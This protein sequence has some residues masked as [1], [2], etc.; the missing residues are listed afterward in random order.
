M[1]NTGVPRGVHAH[2]ATP[3]HVHELITSLHAQPTGKMVKKPIQRDRA[4]G[5]MKQPVK[6][7][8][9]A[10]LLTDG[11]AARH[12]RHVCMSKHIAPPDG[13]IGELSATLATGSRR[14]HPSTT[15]T[16]VC[17][18]GTVALR[19][20]GNAIRV[21]RTAATVLRQDHPQAD[22]KARPG[23]HTHSRGAAQKPTMIT[24]ARL[25]VG[26]V[27]M[28]PVRSLFT[29]ITARNRH[30]AD[31]TDHLWAAGILRL[32]VKEGRGGLRKTHTGFYGAGGRSS[33]HGGLWKTHTIHNGARVG[34]GRGLAVGLWQTPT[35]QRSRRVGGLGS[36]AVDGGRSTHVKWLQKLPPLLPPL[37]PPT[38][39][40]PTLLPQ[41]GGGDQGGSRWGHA[42]SLPNPHRR[43]NA[44]R[45][46][47]PHD[48]TRS[49]GQGATTS[50]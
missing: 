27:L 50:W 36:C 40:L 16:M 17:M 37:P 18:G 32:G 23:R 21:T 28:R 12:K 1:P 10:M 48:H 35:S 3:H 33:Q 14:P 31:A 38:P 5:S 15:S 7:H 46:A 45:P 42:H 26:C 20:T 11:A 24:T 29:D 47:L 2:A 39:S 30:L 41:Q 9:I 19:V 34:G 22:T 8:V 44:L 25:P 13:S 4:Y 49:K 43:Q 6:P